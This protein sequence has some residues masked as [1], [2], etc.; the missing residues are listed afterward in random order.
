MQ[1]PIKRDVANEE[2][3]QETSS[4]PSEHSTMPS[5]GVLRML[6]PGYLALAGTLQTGK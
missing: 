1:D 3:L 5:Q 2:L 6:V 4:L